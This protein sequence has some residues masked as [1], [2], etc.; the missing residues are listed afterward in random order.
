MAEAAR[1]LL[2]Y[3]RPGSDGLLHMSP[4]NAHETQSD[5]VDPTTDLAG[6]RSLFPATI[7]ASRLLSRD[8][9]LRSALASSLE[10]TPKL[11]L[12][13]AP[14]QSPPTQ[15]TP[16]VIAATGLTGS[17]PTPTPAPAPAPAPTPTPAFV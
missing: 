15:P 12:M 9:D 6:I 17:V 2:A 3:Q 16:V 7:A 14:S 5:V 1:F 13:D 10:K 8:G 11:P 4:S